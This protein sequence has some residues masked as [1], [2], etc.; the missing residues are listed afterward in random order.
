MILRKNPICKTNL[1]FNVFSSVVAAG[2]ANIKIRYGFVIVV[3]SSTKRKKRSFD[4][5]TTIKEK[6]SSTQN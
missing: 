2:N 4:Y 5:G 6:S 3:N 1:C